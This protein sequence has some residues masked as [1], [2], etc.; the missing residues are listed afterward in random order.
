MNSDRS[1][2]S[3]LSNYVLKSPML[4]TN[5]KIF[6]SIFGKLMHPKWQLYHKSDFLANNVTFFDQVKKEVHQTNA[7]KTSQKMAKKYHKPILPF[8]KVE[9]KDQS[10]DKIIAFDVWSSIKNDNL[11]NNICAIHCLIF[12]TLF[13]RPFQTQ[14]KTKK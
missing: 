6:K 7:P 2:F 14:P 8:F 4:G 11:T 13:Q 10:F 3:T 5:H 12:G 9:K 1:E